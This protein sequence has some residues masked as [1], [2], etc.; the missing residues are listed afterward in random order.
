MRWVRLVLVVVAA[1]A[2]GCSALVPSSLWD[3]HNAKANE[4]REKAEYREAEALYKLAIK[5][6]EDSGNPK[7]LAT[8]LANL[9]DRYENMG[10]D[11]EA[12]ALWAQAGKQ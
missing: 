5:E 7:R 8:V 1:A 3:N 12:Q 6:E 2:M 11:E 9:A 4:H 10:R